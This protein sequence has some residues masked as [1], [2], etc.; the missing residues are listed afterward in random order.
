MP[1]LPSER[2][3]E[4]AKLSFAG[5]KF[6][7]VKLRTAFAF[8]RLRNRVVQ[9]FVVQNRRDE[10][11][12]HPA[13][14]ENGMDA[15]QSLSR[16]VAA[17]FDRLTHGKFA[18][19][20]LSP[21]DEGVDL[22][23]EVT[24]VELLED[25]KQIVVLTPWIELDM[26]RAAHDPVAIAPD[27]SAQ[28]FARLSIVPQ[29]VARKGELHFARSVEKHMVKAN[30]EDPALIAMRDHGSSVVGNRQSDRHAR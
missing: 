18:M 4:I 15:N 30:A 7:R 10:V 20:A 8:A 23:V 26:S 14:V 11:T 3:L 13:F 1:A 25:L 16:A 9:H 21:S 24:L 12:R 19:A 22:T 2:T 5:A 27:V 6:W 17:E 28:Q 29:N